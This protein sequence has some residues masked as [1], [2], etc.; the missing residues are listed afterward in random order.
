MHKIQQTDPFSSTGVP[1]PSTAAP[2]QASF[3][4]Y[5][6]LREDSLVDNLFPTHR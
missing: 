5:V 4:G 3:R 1:A 6:Y 2:W